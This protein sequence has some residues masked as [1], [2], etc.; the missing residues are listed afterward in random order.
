MIRPAEDRPYQPATPSAATSAEPAVLTAEQV[1]E[2]LQRKGRPDQLLRRLQREG[3]RVLKV[4]GRL[5]VR[6]AD[7]EAFLASAD[8]EA[9]VERQSR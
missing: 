2:L 8:A 1:K 6:P 5:G 9:P 3:L 7:L 4:L